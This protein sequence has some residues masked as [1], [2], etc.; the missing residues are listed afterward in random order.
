[1]KYTKEF[2]LECVNLMRSGISALS[3]SKQTGVSRVSLAKWDSEFK[4]EF[5]LKKA[6]QILKDK[7]QILGGKRDISSE[8]ALALKELTLALKKIEGENKKSEILKDFIRPSLDFSEDARVLK[9]RILN[10]GELYEYQ[11]EFLRSN[12]A[13]RIVL[14]ARQIGFSYVSGADALIGALAGRDQLFLS[15]SEEQA[16]ILMRYLR[17]WAER[18]GVTFKKDAEHEIELENGA[19]IKSFAHNFRTVQGFTGD[20][21]MDEFAW[22]PNQKKIWHA[23]VPSIGAIKGRLTILS[24]PFEEHSLFH[25][26]YSDEIK[27]KV[28]ERFCVSIYDAMAGGLDF[29]LQTMRSLFDADT[30]ASAYE[31]QFVDDESAFMSINLIKSCV[32]DSLKNALASSKSALL[33]GYDIGRVNDRSALACVDKSGDNFTLSYLQIYAKASFKEQENILSSHLRTYPWATINMDKTGI[34][35]NLTE[36]M[37][38]KFGSRVNGVYFT[39]PIKEEMALNLKKIFEDG[40]IKIP[41]DQFLIA[42]LHAI[43]RTI[44]AKSFK[45][46]AKRNEYGHADRFWALALA[47]RDIGAVTRRKHGGALIL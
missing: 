2:K 43:K 35:L 17:F 27:Y 33:C 9:E 44:G 21:W 40:R 22:Y 23:F 12:S 34:G 16:L 1:M 41:N 13:F 39:A 32:D 30:W 47:C 10:E 7:I 26:I 46:D 14:K 25:E 29:D 6:E 24:T 5:N 28:F 4:D 20:I 8:D 18:F 37:K 19:R 15:A 3:I 38:N 11:K 31:C 42:D 45:Y 36:T